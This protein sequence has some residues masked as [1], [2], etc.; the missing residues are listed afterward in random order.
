MYSTP[1]H[2]EPSCTCVSWPS[3]APSTAAH[4][5][6]LRR[7]SAAAAA[8]VNRGWAA[9]TRASHAARAILSSVRTAGCRAMAG[10]V[11]PREARACRAAARRESERRR[12]ASATAP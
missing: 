9:R 1:E 8:G 10:A 12:G 7:A 11:R 2:R 6:I 3:V 4:T 5:S